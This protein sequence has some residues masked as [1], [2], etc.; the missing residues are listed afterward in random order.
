MFVAHTA[1]A[2]TELL[3]SWA[4]CQSLQIHKQDRRSFYK[5][6]F[7]CGSVLPPSG[8]QGEEHTAAVSSFTGMNIDQH[9][10]HLI[11]TDFDHL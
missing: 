9:I 8:Q 4:L 3:C 10:F 2:E 7:Q 11:L 6:H 5:R 1:A